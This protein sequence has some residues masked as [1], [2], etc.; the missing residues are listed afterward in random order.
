MVPR[1]AA[2][3]SLGD[4]RKLELPRPGLDADRETQPGPPETRPSVGRS[5]K[6]PLVITALQK[7]HGI[8]SLTIDGGWAG[9][10]VC[11]SEDR[12]LEGSLDSKSRT[13]LP[14]DLSQGSPVI[15]PDT[16]GLHGGSCPVCLLPPFPRS[17][18]GETA[19]AC[20]LSR[21]FPFQVFQLADQAGPRPGFLQRQV[22][23]WDLT[24]APCPSAGPVVKEMTGLNSELRAPI[25][26]V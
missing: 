26:S 8:V 5:Q 21:G 16:Q 9:G 6:L 18:P 11:L 3:E 7:L 22:N 12:A 10:T 14:D 13:E 17:D 24:S 4:L 25:L 15:L 19:A 1:P 23:P 20:R 2:S